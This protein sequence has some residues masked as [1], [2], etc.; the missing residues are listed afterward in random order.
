[1]ANLQTKT[2]KDAYL[3]TEAITGIST[4]LNGQFG[5]V[6]GNL[7]VKVTGMKLSDTEFKHFLPKEGWGSFNYPSAVAIGPDGAVYMA[8]SGNNRIQK[9]DANGNFI[10][11]WGSWGS[12]MD[13]MA[14][15][16]SLS[17]SFGINGSFFDN[18]I[19][20]SMGASCKG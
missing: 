17:A 6:N 3:K 10:T 5:I 8:D 9:F 19:R 11:N 15:A 20:G 2:D 18:R 13:G 12:G 1:M 16:E 4:I 14:P 7:D